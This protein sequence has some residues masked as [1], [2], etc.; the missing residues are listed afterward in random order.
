M[1][2][3]PHVFRNLFRRT[4]RSIGTRLTA[5]FVTILLLMIAADV[6]A[7]WQFNRM[8]APGRRLN[9]ADQA[10]LAVV[11]VHLDVD[12]LRD[13]MAALASAHDTRQFASEAASLRRKFLEDVAHAQELL[14]S[15]PD[16]EQDP[17]IPSALETL[18]VTLPTQIDTVMELAAADDW[19]AVRLR[20]ADQ[21]P[22]MIDLSSLMVERADREVLQVREEAIESAQ[23]VRR[24]LFLVVPITALLTLLIAVAQGWYTTRAITDPL[25]ELDAGAQALARGEF[26][27]EVVVGGEDELATLG[28]AFNY[29]ARRIRELYETVL[30]SEK[31]LRDV[32]ETI[33]AMAWTALP[34][35]SNTFSNRQWVKYTGLSVGDT[36]GSSW[37]AVVHPEDVDRNVENWR[38]SLATGEPFED[39]ARFRRVADGEYRWFLVRAVP[40]RDERGN[41]LK[42]YGIATDIEDRKRAEEALQKAQAELTHVSRVTMMGELTSSIAHEVNQPLAAIVTNADACLRWLGRDLPNLEKARESVARIVSDGHRA[43]KVVGRVRAL[44]KKTTSDKTGLEV[45]DLIQD[46][47]ALVPG[48]LRRNLIQLRTELAPDLP[49]I[50]GDRVQLQQVLLNLVING[51]EAMSAVTDRPRTLL[52]SSQRHEPDSVL[53]AVQDSGVGIGAQDSAKLFNAF[54]TTKPQG[55]G[56]GLKISQSI[57]EA[58]GGRLWA[59]ANDGCGATF[60]FT[61]ATNGEGV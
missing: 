4:H 16:I 2:R 20:L 9:Q 5:C 57:V 26:Q 40:L 19:P 47:L 18:L 14:R 1:K 17:V 33:P 44:F 59:T 37:Q 50:L 13:T 51:I 15:S 12:A 39:E 11:R 46:V 36:A 38:A 45:N 24:Q 43:S 23:R 32:I 21:V 25:S 60:Q 53:V 7:V 22:S 28:K 42:W 48:E 8:A 55:M 10:S 58:H 61:L 31:Q 34:D 35:G 30:R 6:I 49:R 27:H 52:I 54:Y 56:M 41:I 3:K 29:A